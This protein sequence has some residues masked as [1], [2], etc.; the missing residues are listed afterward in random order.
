MDKENLKKLVQDP[1][2]ISGI[3]NYCDRWCERCSF[4]ARC[5]NFAMENEEMDEPENHD[6]LFHAGSIPPRVK[7]KTP[8]RIAR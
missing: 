6:A 2:F 8:V 7:G 5:L 4:T 3:F 1:R